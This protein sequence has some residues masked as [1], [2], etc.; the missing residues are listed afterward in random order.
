[1]AD[2]RNGVIHSGPTNLASLFK[3]F[4]VGKRADKR[5]HIQDLVLNANI[6]ERSK[7]KP[8]EY[9]D[10]DVKVIQGVIFSKK[11]QLH[12]DQRKKKNYGHTFY[13]YDNAL[14][15]IRAVASGENFPYNRPSIWKRP[16]DFWG[17][18]ADADNWFTLA[19]G[20]SSLSEGGSTRIT[21]GGLSEVFTLGKLIEDGV[22]MYNAT[23]GLLMW[24]GTFS[25][26][27]P[28]IYFYSLNNVGELV[29]MIDSLTI[30]ATGDLGKG[31]WSMYPVLTTATYTKGSFTYIREE[32]ANGMWYPLPFCNTKVLEIVGAGQGEEDLTGNISVV[33]ADVDMELVDASS[34]TYVMRSLSVNFAN[35]SNADYEVTI[36]W[37]IRGASEQMNKPDN[38]SAT[39]IIPAN[40]SVDKPYAIELYAAKENTYRFSVAE[41]PVVLEI[42]Y[43][44]NVEGNIQSSS[45]TIDLTN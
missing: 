9:N 6:N 33:G 32:N 19:T 35:T 42:T 8:M 41:T 34:L 14:S 31:A 30:S 5:Y 25:A 7:A 2:I 28:Q 22:T 27:Q 10:D 20:V 21:I 13:A 12:E 3:F 1:M 23:L 44:M 29:D 38:A 45:E 40:T 36:Q 39:A 15:A 37:Q 26:D 24:N 4:G 43:Y 11:T 17:Y 16:A 18:V